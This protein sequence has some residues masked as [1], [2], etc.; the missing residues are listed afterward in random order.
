MQI[1]SFA[2]LA[3]LL[4]TFTLLY[5]VGRFVREDGKCNNISNSILLVAS[6]MFVLWADYRFATVLMLITVSTWLSTKKSFYLLGIAFNLLALGYFKYTNF[7]IESFSALFGID[8]IRLSIILPVGISFYVFSAVGYICDV[9]RGV[10]ACRSF[11]DVAL[12]LS[13]FPKIT[14]GP[15]QNSKDFFEQTDK[16]RKVGWETF[17]VGIQIFVFGLFKKLVL[18]DRLSVFVNQVYDTPKVF[19]SLTVFLATIAYSFQI[20]LDFSG[21]SDMAIGV[22]EII[23]IR[24]PRNF[25]LPYLAHNVTELWKRWHITLSA[26]LQ[27]YVYISLGG[28][29][30]GKCRTYINLILTMLIGGIWHGANWTYMIWGLLHGVALAIHK[31]WME[32]RNSQNKTHSPLSNFLSI[33]GTFCY[34]SFCWIFFRT[35]NID[36]AILIIRRICCFENGVE[37]IYFW[38]P[39]ALTVYFVSVGFAWVRSK[40]NGLRPRKK[41]LSMIDGYYPVH[42]L[43]KFKNL[44]WFFVLCG[45]I[46]C[47]AYTGGSP[48]IYGNY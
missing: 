30:K 12:Y 2:F 32:M 36:H 41:N 16:K 47:F 15:I 24:L 11:K 40:K 31:L 28:N 6:Y 13:F 8:G 27:K 46:I 7:F 26:W 14:S 23:G 4:L 1:V 39:V 21:Y 5:F 3:F 33:A 43:S 25:N 19:G 42:D 20:Y 34:T 45:L 9:K 44:V 17:S 18:A 48:F 29:R 22:A 37:Q 35:E 10:V 38:L